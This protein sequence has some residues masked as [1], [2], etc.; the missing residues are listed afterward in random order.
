MFAASHSIFNKQPI[1][2]ILIFQDEKTTTFLDI[3]VHHVSRKKNLSFPLN[4]QY[5]IIT[6]EIYM[7]LVSA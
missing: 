7:Y 2:Q 4:I 3:Y 5:H 1:C 6:K